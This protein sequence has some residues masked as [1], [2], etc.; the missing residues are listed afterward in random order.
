ML[1]TDAVRFEREGYP[2]EPAMSFA[3]PLDPDVPSLSNI[4]RRAS[5]FLARK[6]VTNSL[7]MRNLQP[8]VTFTF[9]DVLASACCTGAAILE[10]NDIRGTYYVSG[11]GCGEVSPC[12]QL[13]TVE[14]VRATWAQGHELGCHTF[15]HAAVS[16][17]TCSELE[18]DL[19][20]NRL[21]LAD[22]GGDSTAQNFAYPYGFLE[23]L[24]KQ[25]LQSR[26][27][28]CR[29]GIPGINVGTIDL[30]A[31]RAWPL[32]DKEIDRSTVIKLIAATVQT[33]GWLIFYSHD[34]NVRPSRFGGVSPD[35]LEFAISEVKAARCRIVTIAAGLQIAMGRDET[36]RPRSQRFA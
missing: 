12:G 4:F 10:R 26:F 11:G 2:L 30:G 17:L 33:K 6:L 22:I 5:R 15:S 21:L 18:L 3:L 13:A 16:R 29:S 7:T 19:E 36:P 20:R 28:T 23:F 31:L 25:R 32:E 24:T 35:L 14:Q 8:L 9:D 27:R 1:T 34:V